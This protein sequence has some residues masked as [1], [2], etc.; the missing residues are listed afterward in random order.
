METKR[1]EIAGPVL[2]KP[3]VFID[4]RGYFFESFSLKRYQELGIPA[5]RFVQDNVSHSR[6]GVVRGLHYQAPPFAQGKLVQ[7]LRGRVL[8]VALDIR[9]GSPTFGKYVMVE[10]SEVD[11][12]QF[13]IPA[14]FA[15]AFL[16]LEDNTLFTYKVTNP[17][18]KESDRGI[19]WNDPEL[20]IA[21]PKDITPLV[22][23]KD[24]ALPLLSGIA[25][26]FVFGEEY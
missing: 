25:T 12:S 26:D 18:H 2:L 10:L 22:S 13:W 15:H 21:W 4:D 1:F 20:G 23:P 7:V 16:A 8:D 6:R 17:Y 9:T 3:D 14:G 19:L 11:H 24:A 5:E